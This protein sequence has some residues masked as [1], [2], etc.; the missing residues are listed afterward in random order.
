MGEGRSTPGRVA[1]SSQGPMKAF[2]GLVSC[3][4]VHWQRSE[5]VL[6]PTT[7]TPLMFCPH[8]GLNLEPSASQLSPPTDPCH[9]I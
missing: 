6:S 2:V 3:S 1:S 5:G 4:K 9:L 7:R 8:R